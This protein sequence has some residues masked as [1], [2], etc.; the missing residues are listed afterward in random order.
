MLIHLEFLGEVRYN[1]QVNETRSCRSFASRSFVC[2]HGR[3]H[4]SFISFLTKGPTN[5]LRQTLCEFRTPA[6]GSRYVK[7]A[8]IDRF[9][10]GKASHVPLFI[11]PRPVVAD[12]P[13]GHALLPTSAHPWLPALSLR[14]DSGQSR[15]VLGPPRREKRC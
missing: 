2:A 14:Q 7:S 4:L 13:A 8:K 3:E 1:S 6:S 9:L 15:F 5:N 10:G 12:A 11:C